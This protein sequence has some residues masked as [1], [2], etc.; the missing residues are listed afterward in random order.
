MNERCVN[1]QV[2]VMTDDMDGFSKD[3]FV[4]PDKNSLTVFRMTV[5]QFTLVNSHLEKASLRVSN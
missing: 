2:I 3:P 4:Q 5:A 1:A